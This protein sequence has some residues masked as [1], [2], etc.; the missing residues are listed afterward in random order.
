MKVPNHLHAYTPHPR[1]WED[2]ESQ[3]M[4]HT[5]QEFSFSE[6]LS[7]LSRS[8]QECLFEVTNVQIVR[9]LE[10]NNHT[11]L[12]EIRAETETKLIIRFLDGSS[13]KEW[14]DRVAVAHYIYE[15]FDL[16]RNLHPF[17][18]LAKNDPILQKPVH[19]FFGLRNMGIP[20]LFEAIVWA[21][22][23]QQINLS[24]AYTL[25]R[26]FVETFGNYLVHQG[27]KYWLFP[28]PEKIADL[29]IEDL[30]DLKMTRKKSEYVIGAA[31]QMVR[32][33]LSKETLLEAKDIK[34]AEKMLTRIRGIGPWTANYVCMRCLRYPSAFPID[35][36]GLHN[37][38]KHI[39]GAKEKPSKEEILQYSA[40]WTD[41]E[42]YATFYLWRMLY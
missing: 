35:D 39:T 26:R 30:A 2:H 29:T 13:P 16:D 9:A 36:V 11:S 23:G 8:D 14:Q 19:Q 18:E 38:I 32:G 15:W 22:L 31:Q 37:S 41:W 24:F 42:A 25:K 3:L 10:L 28:K 17:Y 21:I 33:E 4:I 27:K 20:D 5:P 6:N 12:I 34:T 40:S 1:K 7:Y